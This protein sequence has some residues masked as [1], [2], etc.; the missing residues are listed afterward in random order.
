ML[1]GGAQPTPTAV[2]AHNDSM[3]I[4]ALAA[5]RAAGLACPADVSVIGYNDAPLVEHLDPPLSTIAFPGESIGRFAGELV[6]ALIEESSSRVASM[7]FPPEL[8]ARASTAPPA[9]ERR[10]RR[11]SSKGARN[12]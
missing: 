3:A 12:G 2:F 5:I 9:G 11:P 1:L 4:G 8:V 6:I 7:T 10:R